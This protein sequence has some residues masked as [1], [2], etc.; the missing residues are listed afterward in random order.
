M[1][2]CYCDPYNEVS[3]MSLVKFQLCSSILSRKE[4]KSPLQSDLVLGTF[5]YHVEQTTTLVPRWRAEKYGRPTG[6][7]ALSATAV[8]FYGRDSC[9][10]LKISPDGARACS[11]EDG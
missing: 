10:L 7:L 1:N 11:M 9:I 4:Y 3:N 5:A 8:C 2:Y 6:A